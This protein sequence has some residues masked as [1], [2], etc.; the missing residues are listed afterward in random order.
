MAQQMSRDDCD[1][2]E[3]LMAGVPYNFDDRAGRWSPWNLSNFIDGAE[4]LGRKTG[5]F[6]DYKTI[7]TENTMYARILQTMT[8]NPMVYTYNFLKKAQLKIT[9]N[10]EKV[11][12]TSVIIRSKLS[13][14]LSETILADRY[15][16]VVQI[17]AKTRKPVKYPEWFEQKYSYLK[18]TPVPQYLM[19][20]SE[21][22]EAPAGCFIYKTIVRYS[23]LDYNAHT[24]QSVYVKMCLDCATAASCK[25]LLVSFNRDISLYPLVYFDVRY[26]GET[27]TGD[28]LKVCLWQEDSDPSILKFI[29]CRNERKKVN[30]TTFRFNLQTTVSEFT[31]NVSKL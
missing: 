21:I 12:N 1:C 22:P 31:R 18:E 30:Y 26:L 15:I 3:V 20:K 7:K 6:M 29:I 25:G 9:T 16:K 2:T 19:F 23:D 28:E 10:L 27:F 17:S 14:V 11:G 24:N 5:H 8:I 4:F 13:D